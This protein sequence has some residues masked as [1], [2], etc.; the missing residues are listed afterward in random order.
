MA[1]DD[2]LGFKFNPQYNTAGWGE[3]EEE[4]EEEKKEKKKN[5]VP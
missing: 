3:E 1:Q 5:Q 4:E 2:G